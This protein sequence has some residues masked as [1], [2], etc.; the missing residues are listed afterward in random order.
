MKIFN[1]CLHCKR[2]GVLALNV[3]LENDLHQ[4]MTHRKIAKQFSNVREISVHKTISTKSY[5]Y[6]IKPRL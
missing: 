4:T 2:V 6:Q 5:F 1:D 3:T